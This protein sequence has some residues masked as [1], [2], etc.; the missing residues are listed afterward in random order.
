M[1]SKNTIRL[2]LIRHRQNPTEIIY[3]ETGSIKL[4]MEKAER[5]TSSTT[6]FYKGCSYKKLRS[7]SR[8]INTDT[9]SVNSLHETS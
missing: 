7:T 5:H 2:I 6:Q 4:D 9:N 8:Y 1:K 3:T